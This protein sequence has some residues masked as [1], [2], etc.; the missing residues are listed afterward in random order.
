MPPSDR[1]GPGRPRGPTGAAGDLEDARLVGLFLG[2]DTKA[3]EALVERHIKFAGAVAYGVTADF[4]AAKDVVQDAFLRGHA[5][6]GGLEKRDRFRA[7]FRNVVRTT[8]LDWRRKNKR[9]TASLDVVA[10]DEA[11]EPSDDAAEA[12]D[13]RL[14]R[15]ELKRLVREEIERLPEGHREVVALKYI[16]GL[17]YEEIVAITGLSVATIE[18]R[19]WRARNTLRQRFERALGPLE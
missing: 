17:S 1:G 5:G 13:E 16:D 7:W 3:F 18:S 10:E 14:G 9:G 15:D 11:T 6:L 2:G 19:L 8:A 12:V 4:H